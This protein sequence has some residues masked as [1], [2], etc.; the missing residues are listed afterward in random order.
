MRKLIVISVFSL[1]IFITGSAMAES[2]NGRLGVVARVGATVPLKDDFIKGTSDT[3]AGLV[4]GGGL[5][6]GFSEYVAADVEVLHMPKLDVHAS[7]VKTYEATVTDVALGLQLRFLTSNNVVPYIGLGPDFITADLR[8]VNGTGYKLD[9]TYGGHV[10]FGF[11]WFINP[12]VAL[13][14]DLRGVYAVD[15]DVLSGS[16]KVSEY[17]PQWFQGTV[18]VRLMLPRGF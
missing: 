8:H 18:G 16:S 5:I 15:G 9:W 6:Y 12:G 11:D 1:F 14:T 10:N 13:T 7:G 4:A 3:K 2:I 17:S